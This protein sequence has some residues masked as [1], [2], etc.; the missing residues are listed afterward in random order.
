MSAVD[1]G[2]KFL[3]AMA[4]L[5]LVYF[6]IMSGVYY[7]DQTQ[8]PPG[9]WPVF[10]VNIVHPPP[11]DYLVIEDYQ[12]VPGKTLNTYT[13]IDETTCLGRCD[14]NKDCISV[15]TNPSANSCMLYGTSVSVPVPSDG[16]NLYVVSGN[17]PS[18]QYFKYASNNFTKASSFPAVTATDYMDCAKQ[19][20]ANTACTGFTFSSSGGCVLESLPM[21]S[22]LVPTAGFDSYVLSSSKFVSITS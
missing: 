8:T 15:E 5:T 1:I 2:L 21:M 17:E 3:M 7:F 18:K 11:K 6:I 13:R 12:A 9:W 16:H 4:A 20:T 22:N 19:C 14:K 10:I